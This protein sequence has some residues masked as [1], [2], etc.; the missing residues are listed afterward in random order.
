MDRRQGA[1]R[2]PLRGPLHRHLITAVPHEIPDSPRG[3]T[4]APSVA[5]YGPK[6][7]ISDSPPPGIAPPR[8]P[9]T[10]PPPRSPPFAP[11]P[12]FE[13]TGGSRTPR[14]TAATS[15]WARIAPA[16]ASTPASSPGSAASPST[17]S[18]PTAEAHS[19]RT[20]SALPSV[21]SI[22]S[23]TFSASDSIEQPCL[24]SQCHAA[25]VA[26]VPERTESSQANFVN[27]LIGLS[28]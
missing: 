23:S 21:A 8:P 27:G 20:A 16:S 15:L 1:V 28:V 26:R 2:H 13:T 12:P 24:P 18:R 22:T 14:I 3:H 19:P 17:S 5:S 7:G 25:P 10:S 11:H 4:M 6:H 9:S